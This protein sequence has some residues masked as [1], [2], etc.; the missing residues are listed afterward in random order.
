MAPSKKWDD[1]SEESSDEESIDVPVAVAPRRKFEDEEDSDDVA[2]NW[3]EEEDS[4]VEREKAAKA[5][6]AKAKADAEAAANKKSKAQRIEEHREANRLKRAEGVEEDSSDEDEADKRARLRQTE[7]D[8]DLKHAQDLF[9]NV[10]MGPKSRSAPN[11]ALIIE[12]KENPGQT[13]DL[14]SL[15]IFK[16][17]T[18]G[19]FDALSATLVPLLT[20]SSSKPHYP[21]WVSNFVK[22]ICADLPSSEIKKA[23]SA[24]TALSNEKLK[25]EKAQEKGGKKSKAAKTKSSL[26]ATR[27]MGRGMAD[28]TSYEDG[29]EE[30]DFM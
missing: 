25:E 6:A 16:P 8:A 24:L 26:A 29:L 5:A 15:A 23:A 4:E 9:A 18:K 11:K 7:Q 19:Q 3:E 14:S 10:G 27:D 22:Q 17:A 28:T 2:D 20:Q 1:E 12:D 30:D 13:I 21:I